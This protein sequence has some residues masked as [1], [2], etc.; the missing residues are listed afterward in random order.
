MPFREESSSAPEVAGHA[1]TDFGIEL[2]T[3]ARTAS[4]GENF[5]LSPF[6][7][8]TVLAMVEP[9]SVADGR[10]ELQ[11]V[12]GID[13]PATYHSSMNALLVDLEDRR[14]IMFESGGAPDGQPLPVVEPPDDVQLP[15]QDPIISLANAAYL[16]NGY[17]FRP[18]YLDAIGRN[19]GTGLHQTDFASNPDAAAHEINDWV[20][21]RTMERIQ[22]LIPDGGLEPDTVMVL[23]NAVHLGVDWV[24]PFVE[25]DTTDETF[26][27][28]DGADVTVPLMAGEADRSMEASTW[29]GGRKALQGD[30]AFDVIVPKDGYF[31]EV[32]AD[33]GPAFDE[34]DQVGAP[35]QPDFWFPRFESSTEARP[36][37]ALRSMGLEAVFRPGALTGISGSERMWVDDIF[38]KV[39]LAVDEEGVEAAAATAMSLRDVGGY[40]GPEP[41][42]VR[43]DRPCI[44]RIHDT[45]TGTTLF[46]G[47]I[48]DPTDEGE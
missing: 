16:Q 37:D 30:L 38:H 45:R 35:G 48:T 25:T 22:D 26:H 44:Y 11:A 33:V 8:A 46:I 5:S 41:V 43:V 31:E 36:A 47:Q 24:I 17:P 14:P 9:G 28:L 27:V 13:D 39:F 7:I 18:E 19:Y 3:N 10:T 34:L 42:P 4:P 23:V 2:F 32:A 15:E 40:M 21:E 20:A 1:I 6:S 29:L 12:L